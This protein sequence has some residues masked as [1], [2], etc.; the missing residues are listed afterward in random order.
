MTEIS[1]YEALAWRDL[2]QVRARPISRAM[3]EAGNQASRG[4]KSASR[5]LSA[6]VE[7]HPRLHGVVTR[8]GELASKGAGA[9]SSGA[10]R[11]AEVIP[12][13]VADWSGE[14]VGSIRKTV[15]RVFRAGL[16]PNRIVASHRAH[17][18]DVQKL[19][20]LRT[21]GLEQIDAVRG[22]GTRWYYPAIA[23]ASGAGAAF[24]I[25]GGQL[26]TV[27]SAGAAAAPSGA[28]VAG[29]V[30]GDAALVLGI[31]SRSVGHIGLL[32]GYDP[33]EPTEKLFLLSIVNAGTAMSSSAK[34][35]AFSDISQL[36]QAL[37][38]GKTWEVLDKTVISKVSRAFAA[39]FSVRLTKQGLGKFI[40][41]AGIIIGSTLNWASLESIVDS[42]DIAYR[43]RFLLEKHP[44][45]AEGAT[46]TAVAEPSAD[47]DADEE[48][49]ILEE[50]AASGGP[51]LRLEPDTGA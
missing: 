48:I 35:A 19:V 1:E 44:H 27:A 15:G 26:T 3:R 6:A 11:A 31:A 14:A 8:G 33:E 49:S 42:A 40:P 20:D 9:V 16:S 24:V 21:L 13:D 36:T 12:D 41:A 32:Y 23:A 18:H 46:T 29:A 17:G 28:A 47:E 37:M 39:K 7:E 43:R 51:D 2:Q 45:L 34:S 38:R 30:V 22:R 5:R 50:L 25:S 10:R 4:V